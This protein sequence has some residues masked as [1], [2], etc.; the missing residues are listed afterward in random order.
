MPV[1]KAFLAI[2]SSADAH[3]V[4]LNQSPLLLRILSNASK[5]EEMAF[6]FPFSPQKQK[7]G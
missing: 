3:R 7:P 2:F 6:R 1:S 5:Q 4:F